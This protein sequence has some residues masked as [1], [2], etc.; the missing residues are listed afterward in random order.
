M[1]NTTTGLDEY[2]YENACRLLNSGQKKDAI[3]KLVIL[4]RVKK[5]MRAQWKLG[6]IYKET[7]PN[8]AQELL[9][10]SA[11]QGFAKAMLSLGLFYESRGMYDDAVRYY[12]KG[13]N[14]GNGFSRKCLL[15]MCI[16]GKCD[17]K[18]AKGLF[19]LYKNKAMA[20]NVEAMKN[21]GDLYWYG[22]DVS[23][24]RKVAL[25]WYK[26]AA[27]KGNEYCL[28]RVI[29]AGRSNNLANKDS[30]RIDKYSDILPNRF[31]TNEADYKENAKKYVRH[32]LG[33]GQG[34]KLFGIGD[35]KVLSVRSYPG[36]TA[37][38]ELLYEVREL[39]GYIES[40]T[41]YPDDNK[42]PTPKKNYDLWDFPFYEPGGKFEEVTEKVPIKETLQVGLC[43]YCYGNRMVQ[44]SCHG[45]KEPC[46]NCGGRGHTSCIHCR[47]TGQAPCYECGG[48][49]H[50]EEQF[51][52]YMNG[53]WI[54]SYRKVTCTSCN[55]LK[56]HL[57]TSC[58][59]S[60]KSECYMCY[61]R[62]LAICPICH[63]RHIVECSHCK[64]SGR[65]KL[66]QSVERSLR[67]ELLANIIYDYDVNPDIYGDN[68]FEQMLCDPYG[69]TLMVTLTSEYPI[70][71]VDMKNIKADDDMWL[72]FSEQMSA[73]ISM[74]KEKTAIREYA[75][76]LKFR[77][78]FY[79]REMLEVKF[80]YKGNEHYCHIDVRA[81]KCIFDKN[82][83]K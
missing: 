2:T 26:K 21:M 3:D 50:V 28:Q 32:F 41:E 9:C 74:Y 12:I 23:E 33:I 48:K 5:D 38:E 59:G 52:K 79:Q 8:A 30:V 20:G 37:T 29:E 25:E 68:K 4:A 13:I 43:I 19:G 65:L 49:G 81:A 55:G 42:K 57:C 18:V 53:E 22:I 73:L 46:P 34:M 76:M 1:N 54:I 6:E 72:D 16:E 39:S 67:K 64:G 60:G 10:M 69:D 63:G 62:G 66:G 70:D 14:A 61:G 80:K 77:C 83:R 78:S 58:D 27:D 15:R 44:C 40:T 17:K 36:V 56:T 82:F 24:D 51:R 11:E 71:R 47:G 35:V 45:K 7:I 75:R 31:V